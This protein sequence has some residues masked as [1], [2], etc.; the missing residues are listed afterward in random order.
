MNNM[1]THQNMRH[2]YEKNGFITFAFPEDLKR[3]MLLHIETSIRQLGN[4]KEQTIEEIVH[5]V[6]DEV[7]QKKMSRCF[8]MF[9]TLLAQQALAWAHESFCDT[10]GKKRSAVN[11]VLPQ[12]VEE[13]PELTGDHLAIY[14]RCVRPGKPD[15]GRPHRD[16]SFWDLEFKE[17]YDPKIPFPFNYLNNCMKIWIPLSGCHPDTT[18]R[19]I[20][21]SHTME[22]PTIV[23]N[24]E[25]GRRPTISQAWLN[26]NQKL[27]VSP[28]ELSKGSCI[29]FDMNLV[30]MGPR[31]TRSEVRI[32]AEFNFITI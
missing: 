9:P 31:H 12:E 26:D 27:F 1:K 6:P 25:Y 14:W 23:E 15:A 11:V 19:V 7:W 16:A 13:N 18:L 30:H 10:F 5:K 21:S 32:S 28:Y 4:G 2:E 22:I 24:T 17:G 3:E 8:R 29:L 20:P